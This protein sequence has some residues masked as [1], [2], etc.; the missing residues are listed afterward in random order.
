MSQAH[1]L[2]LGKRNIRLSLYFHQKPGPFILII[3]SA[4]N[5]LEF[6]MYSLQIK[7]KYTLCSWQ[8]VKTRIQCSIHGITLKPFIGH[9]MILLDGDKE[10]AC[11]IIG[12]ASED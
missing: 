1:C 3:G 4:K 9:T 7:N 6:Y 11:G 8:G 12:I 2:L 10:I 5:L